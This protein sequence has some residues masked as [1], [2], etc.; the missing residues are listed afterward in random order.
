MFLKIGFMLR[1]SKIMVMDW[2]QSWKMDSRLLTR[3]ATFL[4]RVNVS[5]FVKPI[6]RDKNELGWP[7]DESKLM[8]WMEKELERRLISFDIYIPK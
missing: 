7:M 1:L 3:P 5:S 2:E 8:L 6:L 4:F